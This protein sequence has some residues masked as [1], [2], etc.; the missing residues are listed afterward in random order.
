MPGNWIIVVAVTDQEAEVL[1]F[2]LSRSIGISTLLRPTGDHATDRTVG[3]TL[4]ILVDNYGMPLPSTFA[5]AVQ[6][7]IRLTPVSPSR[8][9]PTVVVPTPTAT[10]TATPQP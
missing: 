5:S 4:R 9:A 8:Y 7:I 1:S 6:Q 10:A 3:A 2:A